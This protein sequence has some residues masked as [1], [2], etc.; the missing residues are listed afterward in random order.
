MIKKILVPE[1]LPKQRLFLSDQGKGLFWKEGKQKNAGLAECFDNIIFLF[2]N[3]S[4]NHSLIISK[5]QM[6]LLSYP[7]LYAF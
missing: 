1:N 6:S 7:H 5:S 3:S 4:K 2:I